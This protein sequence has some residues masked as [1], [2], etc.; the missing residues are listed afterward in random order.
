MLPEKL[1]KAD[2]DSFL[3]R[4]QDRALFDLPPGRPRA[5]PETEPANT[6]A[7]RVVHPSPRPVARE[8]DSISKFS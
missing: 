5:R 3:E 6:P 7:R 1:F 8:K 2:M 4:D